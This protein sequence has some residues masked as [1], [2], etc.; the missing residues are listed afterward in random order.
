MKKTLVA[1]LISC[2]AFSAAAQTFEKL[3]TEEVIGDRKHCQGATGIGNV[4][5]QFYDGAPAIDI[6]D[7]STGK[8]LGS[9]ALEGKKT[10][11][12]NNAV[13]SSTYYRQ[14]DE[15]PLIYVSQ[16]NKAEHLILVFRITRDKNG[17]FAADVVQK[18]I[19]PAPIEM[20]LYY[21]NVVMDL[22][23]GELIITGFTWESWNKPTRGN[24][25][26]FVKFK[27]PSAASS[28]VTLSTADILDR[29]TDE[30]LLATQGAAIK[31]GMLYQVYGG[32]PTQFICCY[33]LATKNLVWKY[34]L[35]ESGVPNEPEGLFIIRDTIYVVDVLKNV[36]SLPFDMHRAD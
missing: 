7:L 25:L 20:G 17:T 9:V 22:D 2:L 23:A 28:Q 8:A 27:T 36:Y 29:W 11:H 34:D 12:C 16:E 18:I 1:I 21:P 33:N 13:V 35:I 6:Y 5:F 3:Y 10:Y 19:L 24:S 30:F 32:P 15:F 31:G 14:G 4:I 26:Q